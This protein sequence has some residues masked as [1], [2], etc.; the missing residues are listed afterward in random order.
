MLWEIF[1][2]VL[3]T[4]EK[5]SKLKGENQKLRNQLIEKSEKLQFLENSLNNNDEEIKKRLMPFLTIIGKGKPTP[6]SFLKANYPFLKGKI[7]LEIHSVWHMRVG[8][9]P[10]DRYPSDCYKLLIEGE[11]IIHFKNAATGQT[12]GDFNIFYVG[13]SNGNPIV[14]LRNCFENKFW[15]LKS[16]DD[17]TSVWKK[18][19]ES[20]DDLW[21]LKKIK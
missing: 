2:L 12:S 21:T 14:A 18:K 3:K 1:L 20:S 16:K 11:N 17:N 19:I 5:V 7:S 13:E 9:S 4:F 6:F 10:T 8:G 15:C